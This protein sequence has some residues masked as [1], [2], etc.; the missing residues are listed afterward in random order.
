MEN[1]AKALLMAGGVLLYYYFTSKAELL[2][3]MMSRDKLMILQ[4]LQNLTS[5]LQIMK[6]KKYMDMR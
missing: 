5:N 4:M 2:S 3:S 6:D 1:S